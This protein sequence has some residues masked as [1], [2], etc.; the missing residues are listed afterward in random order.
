[1]FFP[2][3][4]WIM[5]TDNVLLICELPP[6]C[7]LAPC[8]GCA[9]AA[10]GRAGVPW[11]HGDSA[12]ATSALTAPSDTNCSSP[13]QKV[14]FARLFSG[15]HKSKQS[16]FVRNYEQQGKTNLLI[17]QRNSAGSFQGKETCPYL[18]L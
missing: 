14:T 10:E 13:S 4:L 12:P 17:I 16:C 3:P 2:W 5:D 7:R 15:A 8:R 11:G 9:S 1:M 6:F 18:I